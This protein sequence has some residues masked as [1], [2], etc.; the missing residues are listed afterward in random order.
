MHA[1]RGGMKDSV[2][3]AE[4]VCLQRCAAGRAWRSRKL[5]AGELRW[6]EVQIMC[7]CWH[8]VP[9]QRPSTNALKQRLLRISDSLHRSQLEVA[10]GNDAMSLSP[11]ST[12]PQARS[13]CM[14]RR[15]RCMHVLGWPFAPAQLRSSQ[16][17]LW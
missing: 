7:D 12:T 5:D 13:A 9:E 6:C 3:S 10:D 17:P 14:P 8:S 2:T 11:F 16:L 15:L 1:F 4:D